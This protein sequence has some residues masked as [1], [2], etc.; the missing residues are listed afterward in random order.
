M[1]RNGIQRR[2]AVDISNLTVGWGGSEE[3]A[4]EASFV[5]P[6][7]IE[8]RTWFDLA[9]NML[10]HADKIMGNQSDVIRGLANKILLYQVAAMED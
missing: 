7:D 10:R 1:V 9:I 8:G 3:Y 2:H 6:D 5:S 4:V